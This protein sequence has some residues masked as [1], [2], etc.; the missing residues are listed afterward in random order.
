MV[1]HYIGGFSHLISITE[2]GFEI[3][4]FVPLYEMVSTCGHIVHNATC[5]YPLLNYYIFHFVL[6]YNSVKTKL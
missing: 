6:I 3:E 5:S 1:K 4:T 2:K